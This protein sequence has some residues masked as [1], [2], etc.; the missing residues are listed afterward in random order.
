MFGRWHS[1]TGVSVPVVSEHDIC[2]T[3]RFWRKFHEDLGTQFHYITS[4]HPQT[5]GQSERM[6]QV[7][8]DMFRACVPDFGGSWDT[9]LPLTDFSYKNSYHASIDQPPFM[10][11]YGRKCRT[12]VCWGEVGHWVMG[13]TEV[14]LKTSELI[15]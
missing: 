10:V 1:N 9:Y 12:P 6:I 8:E 5:Y 13:S 14:V 7:L 15:Q 2:F 3:S 4:Y 11:L